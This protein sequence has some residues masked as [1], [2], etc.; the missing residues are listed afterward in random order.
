MMELKTTTVTEI[1][2]A[3]AD[4]KKVLYTCCDRPVKSKEY[5]MIENTIESLCEKLKNI[6]ISNE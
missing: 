4:L 5:L 2:T 1:V 3:I 6:T